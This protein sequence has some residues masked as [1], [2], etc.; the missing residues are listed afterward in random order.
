MAQFLWILGSGILMSL[1]SLV[2][3]ISFLFSEATLKKMILPMVAFAAGSFMGAAF[4]H[5]IPTV[6]ETG[7]LEFS[8]IALWIM[9]GFSLFFMIEQFLHWHHCHRAETDCNDTKPLNY[10]ILLGDGLHNLLSGFFVAAAFMLNI[11]AGIAAWLAELSHEI[12]QELGDFGILVHGG[13]SREKA[14]FFNFL[15]SLTF[16]LGG[17][18]TYF[19]SPYLSIEFLIP[20]AAGSFI[21][22]AASDLVPE[23]NK[24]HSLKT[25]I[26]H[27]FAFIAGVALLFLMHLLLHVHPS[28]PH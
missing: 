14:L 2:G 21:Y 10:L 23:I 20:L 13:W 15:S 25:N 7:T 5:M 19:A 28:H 12:P 11:N 26:I 27:F 18:I 17:I 22:I 16:P 6:L 3:G 1:F 4:F 8:W 9:V 24:N